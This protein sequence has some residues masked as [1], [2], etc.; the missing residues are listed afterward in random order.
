MS[1]DLKL[2]CQTHLHFKYRYAVLITNWA[3]VQAPGLALIFTSRRNHNRMGWPSHLYSLRFSLWFRVHPSDGVKDAVSVTYFT[4]GPA[5]QHDALRIV[6]GQGWP[7]YEFRTEEA[8]YQ[9]HEMA[10]SLPI[11]HLHGLSGE[12]SELGVVLVQGWPDD[13]ASICVS[14][15]YVIG[16]PHKL[17]RTGHEGTIKAV[18]SGK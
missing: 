17:R 16:A 8:W 9:A 1:V 18:G 7:I 15:H 10:Q 3:R 12:G 14:V 2:M 6:R 4:N 13:V 5:Q 11:T